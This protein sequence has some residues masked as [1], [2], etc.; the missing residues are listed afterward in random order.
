M[1]YLHNLRLQLGQNNVH[2]EHVFREFNASA[3]AL[4]NVALDS[5][6]ANNGPTGI[7]VD[8]GWNV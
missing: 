6:R 2:V 7:I 1:G 8:R 4:A 5:D 3:D